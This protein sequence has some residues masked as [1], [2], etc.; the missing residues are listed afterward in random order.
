MAQQRKPLI[1]VI[2]PI[3][4]IEHYVGICIESIIK[5][6]YRHLEIIL[7]DDGST[8]RCSEICDLYAKKDHRIK[9][10]HKEN[11]GLVAARKAG[12]SASCGEYVGYVDGDDW[13]EADFYESL[14][15][16]MTISGADVVAAGHRRDIF[17]KSEQFCNNI[18]CGTYEGR[19][20]EALYKEM[21]SYQNFYR[22]G[23][24]TYVWSKL[25]QRNV[26]MEHQMRVDERIT[27]GEDAAVTYPALLSCKCVCITDNCAY[28]YRQREDS[29]LKKN[30]PFTQE[31]EGLKYLYEYLNA[32]AKE[33][34]HQ[35]ELQKQVD[36]FVLGICM[37]RSGG[38]LL[39]K[40]KK[41][42]FS[43]F[44]KSFY[45]KNIVLYSAGTFG[46][47][48]MK[49][50][51]ESGYSNVVC[52]VDDDF[53]EYRRCCLDVDPVEVV[54]QTAFDYV[55]VAALDYSVSEQVAKRLYSYGVSP[56]KVLT[57]RCPLEKRHD[58]VGK[59]LD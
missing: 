20:L 14:Y 12:L 16:L 54:T 41:T 31:V 19:G 55:L 50:I 47:Q 56:Q 5:Q 45:E 15:Q 53:W 29:M 57:I 4:Q 59:Y 58:L 25:F 39:A 17:E 27:I 48:M 37:I 30:A 36:D 26:L 32:F 33:K 40:N 49:C 42:V 10:I 34:P 2:V 22:P 23:I 44:G 52:W 1:S 13:I 46:Q 38:R 51:N 8:D 11:E 9:V 24:T 7:V 43:A 28:H 18:A 35:Y 6:T 21:I 3:Y